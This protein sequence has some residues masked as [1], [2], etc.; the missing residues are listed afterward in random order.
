MVGALAT[1]GGLW[2]WPTATTSSPTSSAF[3][4]I[5]TVFLIRS[6]SLT[7]RPVV[8]SVVT[9]PTVKMPNSIRLPPE[10]VACSTVGTDRLFRARR[11]AATR[12]R[13]SS[14]RNQWSANGSVVERLHLDE[15]GAAVEGDRLHQHRVGL[16]PY[17]AV[18]VLGRP[19]LELLQQASPHPPAAGTLVDPHPL[20]VA[21]R[22]VLVVLEG[23]TTHRGPAKVGDQHDPAGR[24]DL[25]R[26]RGRTGR[27]GRSG[28]SRA[29]VQ[30][31]DVGRQ[32]A[33]RVRVLGIDGPDL[34]AG[35]REQP[36]DRAHGF[37][38]LLLLR[39][40]QRFEKA[41]ARTHPSARRA[42]PAPPAPSSVSRASRLRRSA[43]L[44][45]T[46]ATGRHR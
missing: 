44:G 1:N 18:T 11:V 20:D 24:T 38:Q 12:A 30:L 28:T 37:D 34:D 33:P 3:F 42:W 25:L 40:G 43:G 6:C 31:G 46:V 39:V 26:L 32:A 21:G 9:S 36:L 16:E 10:V 15:A 13:H 7:V 45:T 29:L 5:A 41:A 23:T 2:C 8:G 14:L 17:G 22:P 27:S 35:R 4:A 19:S